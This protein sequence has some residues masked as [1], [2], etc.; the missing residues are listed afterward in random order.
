[1]ATLFDRPE[2]IKTIACEGSNQSP[3]CQ[4]AIAASL[5]NRLNAGRWE[6]TL[7]GVCLQRYQYS[8]TLPDAGDNADL[9]RVVNLLDGDPELV[10]AAAAYDTVMAD[11]TLDPS[12]GATHFYADGIPVPNWAK[13]PAVLAVKIGA[14]NF[15]KGV[16]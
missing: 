10:A 11:P 14:V 13:A 9:E 8:E 2:C 3:L 1:M 4:Q 5:R 6:P 16:T 7:A 15:W 12:N